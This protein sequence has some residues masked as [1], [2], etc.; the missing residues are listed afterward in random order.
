MRSCMLTAK[1]V[2]VVDPEILGGK[3]V[4]KGTRVAI[5]TLF[6]HLEESSLD[7]FLLGY[8]SVGRE[9][10]HVIIELASKMLNSF[11]TQYEGTA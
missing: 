7:D 2:I 9:Q 4:F 8:P 10:A 5:Q 3:P 1:D 11:S 6:D